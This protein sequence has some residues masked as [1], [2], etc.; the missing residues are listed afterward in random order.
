MVSKNPHMVKKE[1]LSFAFDIDV[2]K[3]GVF[4]SSGILPLDNRKFKIKDAKLV[5]MEI[6][7]SLALADIA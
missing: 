6:P 4:F 1:D 5:R 3:S 7:C 2:M